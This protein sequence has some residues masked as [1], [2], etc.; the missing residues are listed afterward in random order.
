MQLSRK[1][2][3]ASILSLSKRRNLSF[4][5]SKKQDMKLPKQKVVFNGMV[6]YSSQIPVI[7]AVSNESAEVIAKNCIWCLVAL[8][9]KQLSL[10]QKL[11]LSKLLDASKSEVITG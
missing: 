2:K 7:H 8:S 10:L 3:S 6:V 1:V 11:S 4:D 9:Q 5:S